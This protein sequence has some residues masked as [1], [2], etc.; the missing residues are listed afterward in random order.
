[1]QDSLGIGPLKG[2][3]LLSDQ[4]YHYL[5]ER[6]VNGDFRPGF[7]LPSEIDL[8]RSMNVSRILLREVLQRLELEGF[9]ERKRGVG[10]FVINRSTSHV[11][12]GIEKLVSMSQ[13]IRSRGHEPGTRTVELLSI[14]ADSNLADQLGLELGDPVTVI[15]RVRTMDNRPIFWD[16]N[17]FPGRYLSAATPISTI[18]ESLFSYVEERLGL[19]ITHA[20][21]RLLPE[22]ADAALAHQLEIAEGALLI[23]LAQVHYLQDNTPIWLSNLLYPRSEFSWYIVRTR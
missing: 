14:P 9:I 22:Q 20:V 5:K 12:A 11:E 4:V 23:K 19:Y 10:T 15:N 21:A 7:K 3:D 17:M 18:G 13:V 2:D 16:N 6:L 1:M 8:A